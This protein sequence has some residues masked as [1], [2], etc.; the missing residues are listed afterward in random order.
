MIPQSTTY[1][2]K[3]MHSSQN[4]NILQKLIYKISAE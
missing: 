4:H 2:A 3:S 1:P